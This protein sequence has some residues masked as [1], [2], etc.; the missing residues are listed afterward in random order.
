MC[1]VYVKTSKIE[2]ISARGNDE[3]R[4]TMLLFLIGES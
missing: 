4:K 2:K 1:G 3:G